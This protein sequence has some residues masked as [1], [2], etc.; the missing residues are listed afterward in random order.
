MH[1]RSIGNSNRLPH[2][3]TPHSTP[4]LH[5]LRKIHSHPIARHKRPSKKHRPRKRHHQEVSIITHFFIN[6]GKSISLAW[7]ALKKEIS[8][9][10]FWVGLGFGFLKVAGALG[11]TLVFGLKAIISAI[12]RE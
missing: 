11:F 5:H 7:Q 10:G 12:L 4:T 8:T 1:T 9:H 2:T 3:E 6:L